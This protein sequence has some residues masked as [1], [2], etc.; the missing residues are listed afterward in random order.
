MNVSSPLHV[1]Q[2]DAPFPIKIDVVSCFVYAFFVVL[3]NIFQDE[4]LFENNQKSDSQI[5]AIDIIS[6]WTCLQNNRSK[7]MSTTTEREA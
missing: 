6:F 1:Y 7:R 5:N 4:Q 2:L 3:T